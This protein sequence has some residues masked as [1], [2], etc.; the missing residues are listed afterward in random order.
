M[1]VILA[2]IASLLLFTGCTTM[3]DWLSGEAEATVP[4]RW[5][6]TSGPVSAEVR[7][8]VCVL[9]APDHP[10]GRLPRIDSAIRKCAADP[11]IGTAAPK[12]GVLLRWYVGSDHY[13]M[14]RMSTELTAKRTKKFVEG[15]FRRDGDVCH[16]VTL[17]GTIDALGHEM[18]HCFDGLYH[19]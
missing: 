18:K 7:E 5:V 15:V 10:G 16:V 19:L 1:K 2:A 12:D 3:P 9:S 17:R 8:G 4:L 14:A 13:V 11:T 6:R